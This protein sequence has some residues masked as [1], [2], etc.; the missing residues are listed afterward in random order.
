MA[1]TRTNALTKYYSGIFNNAVMT[2][3][4]T[5]RS[6]P[7][8]SGRVWSPKQRAHLE[9]VERAKEFGRMAISDPVLN[10]YYACKAERIKGLGAW[11][12]AVSDFYK[13]PVIES[14]EFSDFPELFGSRQ[15]RCSVNKW[16]MKEVRISIVSLAGE[17]M[18]EGVAEWSL[19]TGCWHYSLKSD[20]KPVPGLTFIITGIDIPGNV[21]SVTLVYPLDCMRV[22]EFGATKN[23]PSRGTRKKSQLRVRH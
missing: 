10:E 5:L 3:D 4:G 13:M 22:M 8:V 7:D 19:S 9:R 16:D 23:A 12:M 20:D 2:S 1:R 15:I 18:E 21:T 17:P 14:V 6:R 11:H